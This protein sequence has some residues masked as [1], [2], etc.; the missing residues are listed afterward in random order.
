VHRLARTLGIGTYEVGR[1]LKSLVDDGIVTIHVE[2]PRATIAPDGVDLTAAVDEATDAGADAAA[3]A[4]RA[5]GADPP[6]DPK[7]TRPLLRIGSKLA[8]KD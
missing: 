4:T 5:N 8:R 2:R 7:G 6:A 3:P 1:L